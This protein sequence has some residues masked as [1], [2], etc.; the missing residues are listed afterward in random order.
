MFVGGINT[1]EGT[2]ASSP[3]EDY[4]PGFDLLFFLFGLELVGGD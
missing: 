3:V 2:I 4:S 1:C